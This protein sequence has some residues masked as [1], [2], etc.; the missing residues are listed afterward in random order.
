MEK[1]RLFFFCTQKKKDIFPGE[2]IVRCLLQQI[3]MDVILDLE[4]VWGVNDC[5]LLQDAFMSFVVVFG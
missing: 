2:L 3:F 4:N 5:Q 1:F